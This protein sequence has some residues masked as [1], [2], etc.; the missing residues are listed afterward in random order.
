MTK[1]VKAPKPRNAYAVPAKSRR[2]A[3]P[4]THRNPPRDKPPEPSECDRCGA[5]MDEGDEGPLCTECAESDQ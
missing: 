3:G 5:P 1:K 4:M 2:N